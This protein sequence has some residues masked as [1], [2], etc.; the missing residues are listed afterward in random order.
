MEKLSYTVA[1]KELP[2]LNVAYARHVGPYNQVGEA[3]ERL[4]RWAGPRGLITDQARHLAVYRDDPDSTPVDKLRSDAC[5]TVPEG[6]PV[7]GDI[8]ISKIAGGKFA[9]GHFEIDP[10]QFGAA[11]NALMGEWMPASGYQPDDRMCYEL[12]IND[13]KHHPQGK[14]VVDICEP[15][16]PL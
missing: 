5:I 1:V 9:V 12:Y 8:G 2:E 4:Y 13:P 16:K 15:V 3:F 11:W 14:F 7:D 6:T 10:T